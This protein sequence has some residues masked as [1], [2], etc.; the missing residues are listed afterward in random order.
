MRYIAFVTKGLEQVAIDEIRACVGD[1]VIEESGDKRVV[2]RSEAA[3]R[4]LTGLRTVDDLCLFVAKHAPVETIDDLLATCRTWDL[5][6][7]R[8]LVAEQR[9]LDETF[10]ITA[11][12]AGARHYAAPQLVEALSAEISRQHGWAYTA[13]EHGNFDLRVFVERT[14]AFVAIRLTAQSLMHRS[15][16]RQSKPGSLRPTVA[17]AMVLL[18]TRQKAALALVDN[19]CGSGTILCE[20]AAAGH[21]VAGGD[22][23]PESVAISQANLSNLGVRPAA[24]VRQ[25]DARKTRWPQASFDCAVS[26]LPWGKQIHVASITGLFDAALKEYARIVKPAGIVCTLAPRPELLIKYARKHMPGCRITSV[27][28]SFTGQAP[29]IVIAE[30]QP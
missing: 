15:Y 25:L 12:I 6:Q 17:A 16:K 20:S 3:L 8:E 9:V 10:S 24:L 2:F 26:N 7:Q 29:T 28:V 21:R 1:A 22:I 5:E 4:A 27:P 19:F 11:T 30:R 23:D 18:A 13:L 14:T